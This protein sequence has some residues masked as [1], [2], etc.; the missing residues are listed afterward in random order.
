MNS[1]TSSSDSSPVSS[2][3]QELKDALAGKYSIWDTFRIY[4]EQFLTEL[5]TQVPT[6]KLVLKETD[7]YPLTLD[8]LKK[9]KGFRRL[10]PE[11]LVRLRHSDPYQ[12]EVYDPSLNK[13]ADNI[14]SDLGNRTGIEAKVQYA[15]RR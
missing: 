6:G 11:R 13:I 12:I 2:E 3:E 4:S 7:S 10:F 5:Q 15:L 14:A 9:G 1:T 8:I